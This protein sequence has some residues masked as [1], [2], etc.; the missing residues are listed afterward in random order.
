MV[1]VFKAHENNKNTTFA[2]EGAAF[3]SFYKSEM[4][5]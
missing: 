2:I 5:I 4:G 3:H 1:S